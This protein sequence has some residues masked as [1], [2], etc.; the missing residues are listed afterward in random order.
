MCWNCCVNKFILER[1]VILPICDPLYFGSY[2]ID[3]LSNLYLCNMP[4]FSRFSNCCI[5][6]RNKCKNSKNVCHITLG[7]MQQLVLSDWFH[8]LALVKWSI[9]NHNLA[10]QN[11]RD[12]FSCEHFAQPPYNTAYR[13][14]WILLNI[15]E[16]KWIV[17]IMEVLLALVWFLRS[18]YYL[19]ITSNCHL[20]VSNNT[21]PQRNTS[22]Y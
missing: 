17:A 22:Y 15:I 2:V 20:H 4:Y 21:G 5:L 14:D 18:S 13:K 19:I 3:Y 11:L 16:Y 9:K 7:T 6:F 12:C 10:Q 1:K 8:S